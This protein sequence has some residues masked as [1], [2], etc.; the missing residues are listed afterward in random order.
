MLLSLTISALVIGSV[1]GLIALGY[2][3]IYSASGLMTFCQGE[4]L[5]FG[6][7][8]G[9][10]FYRY[11][12]WPFP[13]ALLA[14]MLVMFAI[15]MLIE[16]LLIRPILSKQAKDIYVVLATIALGIV[17]TNAAQQIWGTTAVQF[18]AIF[19]VDVIN[20][21][22]TRVQPEA[23]VCIFVGAVAM[24][25]IHLFMNKM[26][27]GTS[28]RAAAMNPLASRSVGINVDMTTGITWGM[29]CALAGVAGILLGPVQGVSISM[30]TTIGT[31]AFA[32]AV[33]GDYG[34]MYGAIIGGLII[35]FTETFS[36]AYITSDYKDFITY[37]ILAL[38]MV[39]LPRGILKG[40]VYDR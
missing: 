18:P 12:G 11:L 14:A 30:G 38:C 34:N 13:V 33:I 31:K 29:S 9:L 28:M 1:Y 6:A 22:G 40:D 10:S 35:G 5:M 20:V 3:L 25:S 36:A 15:G 26:K 8:V 21:F 32:A 37:G 27:F 4:I 16:R 2:S 23:F 19:G 24:I 17:L 7:F 39:F